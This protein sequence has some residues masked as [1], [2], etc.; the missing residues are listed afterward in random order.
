MDNHKQGWFQ[1]P[2]NRLQML[3]FGMVMGVALA[4]APL[5]FNGRVKEYEYDNIRVQKD[6]VERRVNTVEDDVSNLKERVQQGEHEISAQLFFIDKTTLKLENLMYDANPK[7]MSKLAQ[8]EAEEASARIEAS[9]K[10]TVIQNASPVINVSPTINNGG[11][12]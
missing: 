1:L 9:K 2:V 3:I 8:L 5:Y 11:A 4:S 6:I 7:A 12:K 10:T